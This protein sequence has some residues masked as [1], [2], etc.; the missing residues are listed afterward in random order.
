[1]NFSGFIDFVQYPDLA[2]TVCVTLAAKGIS[3]DMVGL[4][5]LRIKETDRISALQNE[6]GKFGAKLEEDSFSRWRLIPKGGPLT[7]QSDLKINTYEDHRM[8]MA[9]APLAS[10]TDIEIEDPSA[11]NKSYP[12]FWKD[13]Q[14]AGFDLNFK[15]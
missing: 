1:M 9:F 4:E 7:P 6:L 5:S 3:C 2:Q 15:N 8:A 11:V 10:I 14:K 13:L 12:G